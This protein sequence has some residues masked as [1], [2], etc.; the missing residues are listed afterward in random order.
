M[1]AQ[2]RGFAES[3]PRA[4]SEN[5]VDLWLTFTGEVRSAGL[6]H[7]YERLLSSEEKARWRGF[8]FEKEKHRFLVTRALARTVLARY[9]G[10]EPEALVFKSSTHGRPELDNGQA[11]RFNISHTDGL[12]VLA[13]TEGRALGIDVE[14]RANKD[15]L[16]HAGRQFLSRREQQ[17]LQGISPGTRLE[18][19][20]ELWT[21][22]EAYSKARGM[23][24]TLPFDK[25]A[26]SFSR[27]ACLAVSCD[28]E[29]KD[30]ADRWR[31]SILEASSGHLVS[32]CVERGPGPEQIPAARKIVPL[33]SEAPC[34]LSLL[35]GTS[36]G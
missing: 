34:G 32:V 24:L 35:R 11:L 36:A 25:V 19:S 3:A 21:L 10:I 29:L 9:A 18:R 26:F 14:A 15:R 31:F 13:V 33:I 20:L 4:V 22:K 12:V 30:K 17:D 8:F 1:R 16:E 23:G 6:L 28:A 2:E 5:R 27:G 7:S